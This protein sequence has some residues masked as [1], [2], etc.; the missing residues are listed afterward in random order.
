M[1]QRTAKSDNVPWKIPAMGPLNCRGKMEPSCPEAQ[2]QDYGAA[3]QLPLRSLSK[4]PCE[5]QGSLLHFDQQVPGTRLCLSHVEE[6]KGQWLWDFTL[7]V[8]ARDLG[9]AYREGAWKL[10]RACRL[11]ML[12]FQES[13]WKP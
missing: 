11:S 9:N 12:L 6:I 13:T 8:S 7:A 10:E 5:N 2:T 1:V 4:K 3:P